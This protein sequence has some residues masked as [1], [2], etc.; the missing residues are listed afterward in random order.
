MDNNFRIELVQAYRKNNNF[1][2]GNGKTNKIIFENE[3]AS[4]VASSTKTME[5]IDSSTKNQARTTTSFS[6]FLPTVTTKSPWKN[7]NFEKTIKS[8][9]THSVNNKQP[10]PMILNQEAKNQVVKPIQIKNSFE[11]SKQALGGKTN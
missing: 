7:F 11:A 8:I 5:N 4:T 9:I 10:E 6:H 3:P 1:P 2:S